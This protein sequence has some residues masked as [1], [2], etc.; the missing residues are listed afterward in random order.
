MAPSAAVGPAAELATEAP[1]KWHPTLLKSQNMPAF[2]Q[3]PYMTVSSQS[4]QQ[5]K[6]KAKEVTSVGGTTAIARTLMM[7]SLYLFYRTPIKV[8]CIML[9]LF[10]LALLLTK[11]LD[12]LFRPL[13]V[14]YLIMARALMPMDEMSTKRFSFR[15]TS[16]GMITHAVKTKGVIISL[17]TNK[18]Q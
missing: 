11:F 6:K 2:L 5:K 16:I 3:T 7:Q 1:K 4:Y 15:Y 9:L 13:R 10:F 8:Q 17:I 14:D 18:K 12:K